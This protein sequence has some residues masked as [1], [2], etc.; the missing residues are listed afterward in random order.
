MAAMLVL[1]LTGSEKCKNIA[2]SSGVTLMPL[3]GNP[4]LG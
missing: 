1:L 4:F 3:N 2:I